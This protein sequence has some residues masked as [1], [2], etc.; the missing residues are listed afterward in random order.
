MLF[1]KFCENF[2]G[3]FTIYGCSAH[4]GHVTQIQR[5]FSLNLGHMTKMG[6]TPM[7]S[8]TPLDQVSYK[9]VHDLTSE[10]TTSKRHNSETMKQIL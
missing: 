3:R 4:L 6:A 2:K 7:Y 1:I 10:N 9:W 5:T 8:K